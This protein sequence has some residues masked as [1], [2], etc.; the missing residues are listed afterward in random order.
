M[1]DTSFDVSATDENRK[2]AYKIQWGLSMG[3]R[4]IAYLEDQKS[5]RKMKCENII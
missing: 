3:P 1:K 4:E 5:D 2:K